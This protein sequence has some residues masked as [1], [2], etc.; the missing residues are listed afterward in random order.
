MELTIVGDVIRGLGVVYLLAGLGALALALLKPKE[1]NAKILWTATVVI[2]FGILPVMNIWERWQA[3]AFAKE[4]WAYYRKMCAERAGEKI[5]KP[6]SGVKSVLIVKPLPP[7]SDEDNSNQFWYGDPYSASATHMRVDNAAGTLVYPSE[8][9]SP[10]RKANGLD[11]VEAYRFSKGERDPKLVQY[12]F[13]P[14]VRD[15]RIRSIEKPTSR[16]GLSWEDISTPQDRKYWIAG[17]RLSIVDLSDRSVIAERIGYLIEA[18]FGSTAGHR[19]PWL[20]SQGPRTTCPSVVDR[21]YNDRFFVLR[22]LNP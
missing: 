21:D 11:Y 10:S 9:M 13:E 15:Y 3:D 14:S 1:T 19:R 2:L 16:F 12:Y 18:G 17:S 20:S 8:V 22:V 4:A 5:Y 6:Q 7:A